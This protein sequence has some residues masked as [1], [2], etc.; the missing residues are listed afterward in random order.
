[1][2]HHQNDSKL[3]HFLDLAK[4]EGHKNMRLLICWYRSQRR[5]KRDTTPNQQLLAEYPN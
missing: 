3:R 2:H 5:L 1:M 4:R